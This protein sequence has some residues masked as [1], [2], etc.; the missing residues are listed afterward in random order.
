MDDTFTDGV[1]E[2]EENQEAWRW[3]MMADKVKLQQYSVSRGGNQQCKEIPH[4]V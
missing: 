4:K 3:M 2:E 1:Y